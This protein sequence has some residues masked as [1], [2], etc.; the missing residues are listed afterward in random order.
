MLPTADV[1]KWIA[2]EPRSRVRVWLVSAKASAGF[3]SPADD[4]LDRP[5]DFNELLIH[6]AAATFAV[7][8]AGDSMIG[9][10]IFPNDIAV[11]NRAKEP[12]DRCVVL[13][14]VD[15]AF[16]VKT[17][18]RRGNRIWLQPENPAYQPTDITEGMA[19]EVWGVVT[20]AIRML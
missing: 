8:I 9:V 16:T 18:R 10:G 14:L 12:V 6:N 11:V 15:G 19:F 2:V 5:L 13:A 17:F 3:P 20:N 1:A 7:R 4:Y